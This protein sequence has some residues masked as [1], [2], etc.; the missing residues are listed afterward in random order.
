MHDEWFYTGGCHYT[1]GCREYINQCSCN[2]PQVRSD[3]MGLVAHAFEQKIKVLAMAEP[4]IITPSVWLAKRAQ[5]S[6]ILSSLN[7]VAIPNPFPVDKLRFNLA[8]LSNSLSYGV[9]ALLTRS[10]TDFNILLAAASLDDTRKGFDFSVDI[11]KRL[12]SSIS[13]IKRVRVKVILLGKASDKLREQIPFATIELGSVDDI[14]DL[15]AVYSASNVFL[16]TTREDNYP[17]VVIESLLCGTPVVA[18]DIGGIA[19]QIEPGC[20]FLIPFGDI[21]SAAILLNQMIDGDTR[22]LCRDDVRASVEAKHSPSRIAGLYLDAFNSHL[23]SGRFA[24]SSSSIDPLKMPRAISVPP[25]LD[26]GESN[27]LATSLNPAKVLL[28]EQEEIIHRAKSVLNK[29]LILGKEYGPKSIEFDMLCGLGWSALE[30]TGRWSMQRHAYMIFPIDQF[31]S[32][33]TDN[34][35]EQTL[36]LCLKAHSYGDKQRIFVHFMGNIIPVDFTGSPREATLALHTSNVN[37]PYIT[38]G[39]EFPQARREKGGYR[40]LGIFLHSFRLE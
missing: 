31:D 27:H 13:E 22:V 20:G 24:R 1:A 6:Q 17:N 38:V 36:T 4:L 8:H 28:M 5:Q 21:E 14:A 26:L 7:C 11:L 34:N 25:S 10:E 19:E 15:S 29:Y 2:C 33:R 39:F 23:D 16:N 37:T 35:S 9:K 30:A 3:P 18:F 12:Y 32:I 40:L